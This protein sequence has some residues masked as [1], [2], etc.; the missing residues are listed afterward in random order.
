MMMSKE[1][2]KNPHW[3]I[4]GD[5]DDYDGYYINCYECGIQRKAYDRDCDLDIPECC[6][7]CGKKMDL[8]NWEYHDMGRSDNYE[9]PIYTVHMSYVKDKIAHPYVMTARAHDE[10]EAINLVLNDCRK[11]LSWDKN[12]DKNMTVVR[13]EI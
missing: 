12:F 9:L 10:Q 1:I 7:H 13:V 4:S 8:E 11:R 3:I 2:T 5:S 6:P